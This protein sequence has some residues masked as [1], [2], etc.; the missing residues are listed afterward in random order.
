M[1]FRRPDFSSADEFVEYARE[2]IR[3]GHRPFGPT[4]ADELIAVYEA[5]PN[6]TKQQGWLDP[7]IVRDFGLPA[8]YFDPIESLSE[9]E[10]ERLLTT[11]ANDD[12][13]RVALRALLLGGAA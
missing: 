3:L 7:N 9:R 6:Y 2:V 13:F 5:L 12:D 10:Q 1:C 8:D 11:L 4:T